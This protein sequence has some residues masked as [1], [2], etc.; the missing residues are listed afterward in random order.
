MGGHICY[1]YSLASVVIPNG[2]E[3]H[4]GTRRIESKPQDRPKMIVWFGFAPPSVLEGCDQVC[5]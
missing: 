2:Y 1:K 5:Y 3:K 4:R